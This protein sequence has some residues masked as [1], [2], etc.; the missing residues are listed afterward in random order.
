[1]PAPHKTE[2]LPIRCDP[3][4]SG[5][6]LPWQIQP[7]RHSH[8][9]VVKAT[10]E[11]LTGKLRNEADM[12]CGDI[13][14]GDTLSSSL[15]YPS[16]FAILKPRADVVLH[17]HA[18]AAGKRRMQVRFRF[19][20]AFDRRL[21]VMG[22]RHF[23]RDG[24]P[25]EPARFDSLP[26]IWEHAFGGVDRANPVGCGLA[27]VVPRIELLGKLIEKRG[28]APVAA[29]VTAIPP[30]WPQRWSLLGH[31]DERWLAERYPYFAP[32]MDWRFFQ[33]APWAQQLDTLTGTESYLLEG[34]HPEHPQLRG[35]LPGIQPQC[36]AVRGDRLSLVPLRLDTVVFQPDALKAQLIWR[37][38]V[39]V[40]QRTGHDINELYVVTSSC[41][42]PLSEAQMGQRYLVTRSLE[43]G[44][45]LPAQLEQL[46]D[47]DNGAD[48]G[49]LQRRIHARL[50]AA[51][52]TLSQLTAASEAPP[53]ASRKRAP[54]TSLRDSGRRPL[55]TARLRDG[56][57]LDALDLSDSDLSGLDFAGRSLLGCDLRRANLSG[58]DL[59]RAD[60]R[61][62]Q[63]EGCDLRHADLR[64]A[65]LDG[66]DL[67]ATWLDGARLDG[68]SLVGA[69]V[70]AAQAEQLS[71]TAITATGLMAGRANLPHANF[72][73]ALLSLA[74]F[75]DADLRG[76]QF[77]RA[78]LDDARFYRTLADDSTF[79]KATLTNLRADEAQL[80]G[81]CFDGANM[82]GAVLDDAILTRASLKQCQL[83]EAGLRRIH[84]RCASFAGS[85][86]RQARLAGADLK[87]A[88]LLGADLMYATLEGASLRGCDL[89]HAS[90]Y[91]A[92]LFETDLRAAKLAGANLTR[93]KVSAA[94]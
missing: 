8:T 57:C 33:C 66:A 73:G 30:L 34:V 43:M 18:H 52:I 46:Q 35:R 2:L 17:G 62:A 92:E 79:A 68:A 56:H 3:S 80:T 27:D 64:E 65:L 67:E 55:V 4:L 59:R 90:L 63:L 70:V 15:R 87:E 50:R 23:G 86:M 71:A 89:R 37:G 47:N 94:S 12:P 53:R 24:T 39:E 82:N 28:D 26:L 32:D 31:Y 10:L 29:G 93:T 45:F 11:L 9:V 44:L 51:G 76:A 6:T 85:H 49:Q 81:A 22:R 69:S 40:S 16:D 75:S 38:R 7:G 77:E 74:D 1:M 83:A 25:T 21:A 91:S 84:A 14:S 88:S 54:G 48:D 72:S 20:R 36:V 19:G 78:Q 5:A 60:L 13:P 41:D 42:K 58:S 61:M